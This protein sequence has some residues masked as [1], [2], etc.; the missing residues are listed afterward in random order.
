VQVSAV[1]KRRHQPFRGSAYDVMRN[2]K[3][4]SNSKTNILNGDPKAKVNE[5]DLGYTIGGPVG[6]PGG[7][8][9]LFSSTRTSTRA[10]GTAADTVRF[11]FPT[12]LERARTSRRASTTTAPSTT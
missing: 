1:T 10:A 12:A 2:D 6:R 3:W 11:R 5:K 7:R 8:N 4:N 9:K